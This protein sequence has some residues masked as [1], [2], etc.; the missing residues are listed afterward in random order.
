MPS[1]I[2]TAKVI[3]DFLN[4][5]LLHKTSR[6][7]I[8]VDEPQYC[9]IVHV[10]QNRNMRCQEFF[11]GYSCAYKQN[12]INSQNGSLGNP[13]NQKSYPE[14]AV[15]IHEPCFSAGNEIV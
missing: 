9:S 1:V 13:T 14:G 12:R 11:S 10:Y 4:M 8:A 5:S 7:S 6:L 3:L 15:E 2:A